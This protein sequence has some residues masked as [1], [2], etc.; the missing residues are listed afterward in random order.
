MPGSSAYIRLWRTWRL[1]F[2]CTGLQFFDI[3]LVRASTMHDGPSA[4]YQEWSHLLLHQREGSVCWSSS[5]CR[6]WLWRLTAL[7]WECLK[8]SFVLRRPAGGREE[9]FEHV[10]GYVIWQMVQVGENV[11]KLH[12]FSV[13]CQPFAG[14]RRASRLFPALAHEGI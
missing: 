9:T 12:S 11:R 6:S 3:S 7:S 8:W 5:R 13:T 10:E 14:G 2:C 4:R 1:S